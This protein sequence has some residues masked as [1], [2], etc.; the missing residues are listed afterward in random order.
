LTTQNTCHGGNSKNI[1]F[2][3]SISVDKKG[4]F[5]G[6]NLYIGKDVKHLSIDQWNSLHS[7]QPA[8]NDVQANSKKTN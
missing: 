6:V 7:K 8:A 5:T 4:N 1:S 3:V 2:T